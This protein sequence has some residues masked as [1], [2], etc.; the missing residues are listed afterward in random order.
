MTIIN[1]QYYIEQTLRGD[2]NAFSVLVD[3]HKNLVF[4]LALKM[5]K[6]QE[7]A[8]EVAQDAFIKAFKNL[9]SYKGDAKFST[10]LYKITYRCC[11]DVLNASKER[12][13]SEPI[14]ESGA[15]SLQGTE[16]ILT[17]IERKERAALLNRCLLSLPEEERAVI[18]M[19]YYEELSLKEIVATTE[20]S[21]ANV[22]VKLH[23]ARKRLLAIVQSQVEPEVI[24]HY[25]Q[26]RKR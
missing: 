21:E 1:D 23:R 20:L 24:N 25:G 13:R 9:K 11:L 18:W 2:R 8:E 15:H 10:W 22:K 26:K 19:F 6:Q 16:Q 14:E 17:T 12:Y 4:S 3:R 7:R 5:V